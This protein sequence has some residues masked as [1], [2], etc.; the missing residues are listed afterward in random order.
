MKATYFG[1]KVYLRYKAEH[2]GMGF[3]LVTKDS[4]LYEP[5]I[6]F[7]TDKED[8]SPHKI[9]ETIY[10]PD[11]EKDIKVMRISINANGGYVYWMDH[12]VEIIEDEDT[13]ISLEKAEEQLTM[14]NI[15]VEEYENQRK[16]AYGTIIPYESIKEPWFKRWFS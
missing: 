5:V 2:V 6:I 12:T 3:C 10:F 9:G 4:N 13:M 16:E 11:L 1:K 14:M 15:K 8:P 7:E